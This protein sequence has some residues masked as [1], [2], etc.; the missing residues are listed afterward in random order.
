MYPTNPI[1]YDSNGLATTCESPNPSVSVK[2]NDSKNPINKTPGF[3]FGTTHPCNGMK[4]GKAFIVAHQ[5]KHK[6]K[7]KLTIWFHINSIWKDRG[8]FIVKWWL[9]YLVYFLGL[10]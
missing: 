1:L 10:I 8:F 4:V 7:E 3:R 6:I 2:L 9:D 5:K